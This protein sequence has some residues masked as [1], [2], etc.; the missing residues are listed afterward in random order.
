MWAAAVVALA[1][2]LTGQSVFA[3]KR[4]ALVIGNGAYPNLGALKNPHKDAKL[5]AR[6][7]LAATVS[8]ANSINIGALEGSANSKPVEIILREAYGRIG[9]N[10]NVFYFP[11]RRSLKMADDG[12]LDGELQRVDGLDKTY[13]NLVKVP[14]KVGAFRGMAFTTGLSIPIN[15]WQSLKNYK[16]GI[17][18][19]VAF[20]EK[21]T[22][23]MKP[24]SAGNIENLFAMLKG[25]RF[26]VAVVSQQSG[27]CAIKR[28]KLDG[29]TMLPTP[30]EEYPLFHYLHVKHKDLVPLIADQLRQLND[31]GRINEIW[32]S[33]LKSLVC[34]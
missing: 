29:V 6:T 7:L 2:F 16:V 34:Q 26:D 1:V 17:V 13:L 28:G 33:H 27:E 4:I 12:S 14:I 32:S 15:G 21:G 31:E 24:I 10:I 20:V 23:N 19:G 5:M 8:H 30:I 25:G 22:R 9:T 3:E 11:A 18:R